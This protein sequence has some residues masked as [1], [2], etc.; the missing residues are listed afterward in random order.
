MAS[1]HEAQALRFVHSFVLS[2]AEELRGSSLPSRRTDRQTGDSTQSNSPYRRRAGDGFTCRHNEQP[3]TTLRKF[4]AKCSETK[5]V[6][7]KGT[8]DRDSDFHRNRTRKKTAFGRWC[9]PYSQTW[10]MVILVSVLVVLGHR[11]VSIFMAV[12]LASLE[13]VTSRRGRIIAPQFFSRR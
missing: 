3:V 1:A 2:P 4:R 8:G 12:K 9:V 11:I 13:N 5:A 6:D 10:E 7:R